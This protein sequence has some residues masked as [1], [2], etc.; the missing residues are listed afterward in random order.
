LTLAELIAESRI[1]TCEVGKLAEWI[2]D[3]GCGS[4][5]VLTKITGFLDYAKQHE[6]FWDFLI[7]NKY[8]EEV[9][10]EGPEV[11]YSI[12]DRFNR[13]GENGILAQ[14]SAGAV[15]MISFLTGNRQYNPV[16]V[17]DVNKITQGELDAI[18]G[19]SEWIKV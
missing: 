14:C 11:F 9:V 7:D 2:S 18:C 10:V 8:V 3:K 19:S 12:N 13:D 16:A 4:R 17:H 15:V 1:N 6:C 5:S